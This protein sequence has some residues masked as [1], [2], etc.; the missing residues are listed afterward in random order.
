MLIKAEC[1][2]DDHASE[3]EFDAVRWFENASETEILNVAAEDWKFGYATDEI[4]M[5]E[6]EH[7]ENVTAM[8]AYIEVR[9]K[10]E[11]MG[12][13]CSVDSNDA[14]RWLKENRPEVFEKIEE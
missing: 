10:V 5:D 6:A 14:M 8:F 2:S 13:G 9:G 7:N 12:F 11:T 1:H 3:V 4:A